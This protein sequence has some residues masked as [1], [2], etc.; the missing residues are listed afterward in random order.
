MKYITLFETIEDYNTAILDLPNVSLV[1]ENM[2]VS[3]K[4]YVEPLFFCKLTLSDNG[5]VE[6]EGSGELTPTMTQNYRSTLVSAEI[7]KLCTSIA[8][9][10][11]YDCSGLTN[12]TIGNGVTSIGA[13]AFYNCSSLTSIDIPNSVT[14]IG[15]QSFKNCSNLTNVTIGS[16]VTSIGAV[17]FYNC[18]SLTSITSNAITAPTIQSD[19]FQFV[20]TGGT[21][22]V[23]AGSSGYDVWVGTGDYYLGK[24]NWNKVE[25]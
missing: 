14:D 13:V 3:Y 21:L 2:S 7:G 4:P 20:K 25:Q 1:E 12:V 24:Y 19:T 11:F 6:L 22:T 16:G 18:S 5:V 23:P 8:S 17:A 15:V 9:A 10:V